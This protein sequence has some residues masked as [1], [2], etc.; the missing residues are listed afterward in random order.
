MSTHLENSL[1]GL[2]GVGKIG[3]RISMRLLKA[4]QRLA[5]CDINAKHVENCVAY[6][7]KAILN[8]I[9]LAKTCEIIILSLP[10]PEVVHDVVMGNAGLLSSDRKGMII[11]DLSTNS[12]DM[13]K[14]V[15]DACFASG[16]SF[17][18][19]PLTGAII[20][21]ERGTFTVMIGGEVKDVQKVKPI[22]ELFATKI[23]HVG[24]QGHGAAT[25]LLHNMLGEIN[26]YAIAEAFCIAAKM[27]LDLNKVYE[28]F[29][30]GMATS[31]ILTELYA[32]GALRRRF[33]PN[34]TVHTALKDQQLLLEMVEKIKVNLTFSPTVYE[35]IKELERQGFG[36]K[37]VTSAIL[38][39]E[40]LHDVTVCV[41]D[42]VLDNVGH[43]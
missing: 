43:S 1:I 8:L 32:K 11:I 6:G 12:P 2:V 16:N 37:D 10:T 27:G 39:F 14:K 33:E 25:K 5:V 13:V 42:S 38:L 19:A 21:A 17:L 18:D 29:S 4:G 34:V 26:V 3:S 31:R 23:V 15:G 24:P 41:S 28:V 7:A 36:D 9:E 40:R 20:G 35:L 30:H 22:L